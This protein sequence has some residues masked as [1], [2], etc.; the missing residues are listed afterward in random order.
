MND[1]KI[2]SF[3]GENQYPQTIRVNSIREEQSLCDGPGL[4]TVIFLQGCNM[5]C[6]GCH[7]KSSWNPEGGIEYS[8]TELS[9]ILREKCLNKKLTISGGEPLLQ[10]RAV[11]M[12]C[13]ELSDFDLCLYTGHELCDVPQNILKHLRFVKTGSFVE[14]KH[15]SVLPF[16]GSSNQKFIELYREKK[17]A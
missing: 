10:A 5:H 14:S 12:L 2:E 6:P 15:S 7:N 11:E 8:I 13:Q 16:V 17:N 4:R 9:A 3:E 1:G